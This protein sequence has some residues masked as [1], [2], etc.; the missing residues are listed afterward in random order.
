MCTRVK[1]AAMRRLIIPAAHKLLPRLYL[2]GRTAPWAGNSCEGKQQQ[3]T[4]DDR[5]KTRNTRRY[6]PV[7]AFWLSLSR[8][9]GSQFSP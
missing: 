3:T 1:M 9:S 8:L 4:Y 5:G 6:V 7:F 2:S